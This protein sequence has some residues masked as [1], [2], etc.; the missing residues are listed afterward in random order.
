M[1]R[2]AINGFGRV[3]RTLLRVYRTREEEKEWS[4]RDPL[5]IAR[6]K[7][8]DWPES[9]EEQLQEEIAEGL[10]A[11]EDLAKQKQTRFKHA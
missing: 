9:R 5:E 4:H 3:G 8:D 10:E 6:K 2:F 11:A 7:L 1:M